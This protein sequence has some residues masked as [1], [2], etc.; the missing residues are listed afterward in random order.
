MINQKPPKPCNI[1]GFG[2]FL[3]IGR[4][5]FLVGISEL[6][7]PEHERHRTKELLSRWFCNL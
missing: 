5:A 6:S 3:Y 4:I 2:G 1:N 7:S